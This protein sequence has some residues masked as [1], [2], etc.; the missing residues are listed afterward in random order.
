MPP[1]ISTIHIVK[2]LFFSWIQGLSLSF[3]SAKALCARAELLPAVPKWKCKLIETLH[4][5]K[6]PI[7]LF[8]RDPLECLQSI[9]ENPLVKN[10]INFTPF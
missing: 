8:Y 5:T 10:F 4:P 1:N 9:L 3:R 7:H 2:I 6:K